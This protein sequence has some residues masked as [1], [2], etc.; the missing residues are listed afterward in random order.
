MNP[1]FP[2]LIDHLQRPLKDLR[3]SVTDRCNFRCTYCMPK[4]RFNRGYAFLPEKELLTF[5]EL[6]RLATCFVELGVKKI[7]LTGGEPLLRA[8]LER[9]ISMLATLPVDI[10]MTTNGSFPPQRVRALRDAGLK[11]MTISLDSLDD[12]TFKSIN[13]VNFPVSTVLKWIDACDAAGLGPIKINAVIK[14]GVNEDSIVPMARYFKGSGHI[15]RFIEFMDVGR[16][17]GWQMGDVVTA[18]QIH[19]HI[20]SEMPLEPIAANYRGEVAQRWRYS[21]GGGE[22]GII[23]SVTQPFCGDCTRARLTADGSLFTCL[24]SSKKHDLKALVKKHTSGGDLKSA[25]AQIWI[26]RADRYS[27]LRTTSEDRGPKAEMF[28]IGG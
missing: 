5:E 17:N 2:E 16:T 24:F 13:D 15:I 9:L 1:D 12:A 14:K 11:R 26:E 21:D 8:H 3:L 19:A 22:I 18:S 4:S 23:A 7:R 10:S 27:A 20:H 6:F 25:L 28:F